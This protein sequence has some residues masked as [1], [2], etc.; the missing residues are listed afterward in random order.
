MNLAEL[1]EKLATHI[2]PI[3]YSTNNNIYSAHNLYLIEKTNPSLL[4]RKYH[5]CP[6]KT[7]QFLISA[8][9]SGNNEAKFPLIDRLTELG[10]MSFDDIVIWGYL[11]Y[12]WYERIPTKK[13]QLALL[14]EAILEIKNM[15]SAW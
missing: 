5:N 12:S 7:A 9:K 11:I 3:Y 15:A 2:A 4:T 10:I 8:I 13:V 6:D 14:E 1:H